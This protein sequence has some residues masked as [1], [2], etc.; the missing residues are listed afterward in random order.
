MTDRGSG[1]DFFADADG[2][3]EPVKVSFADEFEDGDIG[4]VVKDCFE[5]LFIS[6]ATLADHGCLKAR[7][8]I[9]SYSSEGKQNL[10][11]Y[12]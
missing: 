7:V 3:F 4:E 11:K 12:Q 5:G 8:A 2:S 9:Y 6:S 10:Y 1:F